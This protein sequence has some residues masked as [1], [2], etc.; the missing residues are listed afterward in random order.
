ML[1]QTDIIGPQLRCEIRPHRRQAVDLSED[2]DADA[3]DDERVVTPVLM[4]TGKIKEDRKAIREA[5]RQRRQLREARRTERAA[6][7]LQKEAD[8]LQKLD[9]L[10]F[11][12]RSLDHCT[13]CRFRCFSDRALARHVCNFLGQRTI[14]G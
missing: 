8:L 3:D 12:R 4:P 9:A 1:L 6:G 5:R 13:K 10:G 14:K 2:P 11:G 7:K